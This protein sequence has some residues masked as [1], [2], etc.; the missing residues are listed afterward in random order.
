VAG[1][2]GPSG[3]SGPA[4]QDGASGQPGSPPAGWSYTDP[5][6]V[7]YTCVPDDATPAPN[8]TCSAVTPST[9]ATASPT[10]TATGAAAAMHGGSSGIVNAA[11]AMYTTPA[12]PT[13]KPR[14]LLLLA[15]PLLRRDDFYTL[16]D[17]L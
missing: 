7:T 10:G 3:P 14:A 9:T 8:Y 4:G 5:S 11:L 6:G 16:G 2:P 17:T 1:S 15:V 13:P 12:M